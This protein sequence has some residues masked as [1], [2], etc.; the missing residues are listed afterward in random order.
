MAHPILMEGLVFWPIIGLLIVAYLVRASAPTLQDIP[1]VKYH[2]YLPNF[3]NRILY[4]PKAASMIS[5]GYYKVCM[6]GTVATQPL[7]TLH[8]STRIV[9]FACLRPMEKSSS[10]Q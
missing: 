1:T 3:I 5:Q 2:P 7:L 4:Y 8:L 9:P 10:C 6:L